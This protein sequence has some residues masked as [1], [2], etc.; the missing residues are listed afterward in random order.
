[1]PFL[2]IQQFENAL[3]KALLDDGAMSLDLYDFELK[4][5]ISYLRKSLRKDKEDYVICITSNHHIPTDTYRVAM[6]LIAQGSKLQEGKMYINEAARERLKKLWKDNYFNNMKMMIPAFANS[7]Y[8][9]QLA[10]TGV[11]VDY[12]KRKKKQSKGF[13]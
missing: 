10:I 11:R 7:L 8:E 9:G 13:A 5:E 6:L 12:S 3:K 4:S 1:M 2:S